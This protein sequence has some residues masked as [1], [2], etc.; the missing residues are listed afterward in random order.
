MWRLVR[1][2]N[3]L[4][5]RV[6][7]NKRN[8]EIK[9]L[10]MVR[11]YNDCHKIF[12]LTELRNCAFAPGSDRHGVGDP[13]STDVRWHDFRE[14]NN[15]I[16]VQSRNSPIPSLVNCHHKDFPFLWLHLRS[17]FKHM[18]NRKRKICPSNSEIIT[19]VRCDGVPF[20][21]LCFTSFEVWQIR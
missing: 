2:F 18:T 14:L 6:F 17:S 21:L 10:Q 13:C 20:R 11:I 9:I 16:M 19:W 12:N 8:T 1:E 15:E 3:F 7:Y 4:W 5:K